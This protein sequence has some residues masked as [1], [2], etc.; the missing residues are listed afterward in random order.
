MAVALAACT[1][2][3]IRNGVEV[4]AQ[5]LRVAKHLVTERVQTVQGNLDVRCSDPV[6]KGSESFVIE[7][8][9]NWSYCN[10]YLQLA[11][12]V[13]LNGTGST[14]QG[15]EGN[16]SVAQRRNVTVFAGTQRPRLILALLHDNGEVGVWQVVGGAASGAVVLIRH[17]WPVRSDSLVHGERFGTW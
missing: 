13:E 10:N 14:L 2:R 3:D 16:V 12:G 5:Y 9:F 1:H 4:R 17:P 6:L 15:G 7:L 11:A 8:T